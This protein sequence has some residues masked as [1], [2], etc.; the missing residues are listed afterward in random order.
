MNNKIL[1]E[2]ELARPVSYASEANFIWQAFCKFNE[3][4]ASG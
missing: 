1:V 3:T 2:F 4:L